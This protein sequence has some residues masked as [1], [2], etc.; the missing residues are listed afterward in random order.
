MFKVKKIIAATITDDILARSYHS[1][2][3]CPKSNSVVPIVCK[4]SKFYTVLWYP[5]PEYDTGWNRR[6]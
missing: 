4:R 6:F 2:N 3:P 5:Y 1:Y